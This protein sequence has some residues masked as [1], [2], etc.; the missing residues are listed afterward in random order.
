MSSL[1]VLEKSCPVMPVIEIGAL[2]QAL[3]LA[4]ALLK[5]GVMTM[6]VTLRSDCALA[7]IE[8]L[9]E[10]R[11]EM[12]VGAGTVVNPQQMQ[13]VID[14]GARFAVSPGF[15]A[16]IAA[17]A[18]QREFDWLPG[19]ATA[20]EIMA[21]LAAG[22]SALKLFPATA[23]GGIHLLKALAG[24]FSQ[25]SFCPTGGIHENN[26]MDFLALDNVR[27]VGGSWLTPKNLL[28][29]QHWQG[30][31]DLALRAKQRYLQV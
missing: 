7:A 15:S 27:C 8:L 14:C 13:Q 22:F 30:I 21:A 3:P 5:A 12:C 26:F 4:D 31:E 19:V 6:E 9:A 16:E 11:P 24:P 18:N 2:T 29:A 1:D 23:I 28:A 17:L 20:S 10:Q 25:V